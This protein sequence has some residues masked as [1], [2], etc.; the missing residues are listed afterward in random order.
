MF[1]SR[2]KQFVIGLAEQQCATLYP[3]AIAALTA[4]SEFD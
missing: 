1:P 3:V 4:M 2:T